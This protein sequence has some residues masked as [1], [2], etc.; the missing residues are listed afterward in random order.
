MFMHFNFNF[1]EIVMP[2]AKLTQHTTETSV[3][4]PIVPSVNAFSCFQK[5]EW[6]KFKADWPWT[7][8]SL[9]LK[10]VLD[11]GM[12]KHEQHRNLHLQI[13][14]A[15]ANLLESEMTMNFF[16]RAICVPEKYI[17]VSTLVCAQQDMKIKHLKFQP[18]YEKEKRT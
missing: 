3:P 11:V 13:R 18:Q 16:P 15:S 5:P 1:I 8:M 4:D 14:G 12:Q 7:Q 2:A 6:E 17:Q 9:A 10:R